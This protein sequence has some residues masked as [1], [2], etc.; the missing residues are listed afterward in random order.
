MSKATAAAT[1]S[2]ARLMMIVFV[3]FAL[4]HFLSTAYRALNAMLGSTLQADLAISASELGLL[5][6]AFFLAFAL[7]QLPV[8]LLLDRYGP[9]RVEASLLLVAGLGSLLF[10]LGESLA[11]LTLGRALA[12]MGMASCL[13]ASFKAFSLWFG[14]Q[15]LSLLN[16]YLMAIGGLGMMSASAPVELFISHASWR[17]LFLLL[18][19]ACVLM[20][21]LLWWVVPEKPSESRGET[22]GQQVRAL[23]RLLA[24]QHFWMVAPA[25]F[26]AHALSLAVQGL[27]VGLWFRDVG[28]LSRAEV[29]TH[30]L[31]VAVALTA[32]FAA[33]A[34][35]ADRLRARIPPLW[36]SAA[37]LSGFCLMNL[38]VAWQPAEHHLLLWMLYT[39]L[40]ASGTLFYSGLVGLHEP[41][42]AGRVNTALNLVV[43]AGAFVLQW[44]IGVVV[45]AWSI[46]GEALSPVGYQ[47]AFGSLAGLQLLSLLWLV[48]GL[49]QTPGGVSR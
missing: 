2:A 33:W 27:W 35:L 44:G 24:G 38:L 3:P 34:T 30:L 8:G 31:W 37:G 39:F 43:F 46:P 9:R 48:R 36:I 41:A 18:A 12:G 23:S 19:V 47:V 26:T 49:R 20:A 45:E 21:L 11:T 7:A 6:S 17:S 15:R 29:G 28:G 40:G 5:T 13:M 14:P 32:G 16:G 10:A 22:L 1:H 42:L 4:G 25:A